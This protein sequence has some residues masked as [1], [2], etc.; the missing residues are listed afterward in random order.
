M[1]LHGIPLRGFAISTVIF[2]ISQPSVQRAILR[3]TRYV[4]H[5][6]G[7]TIHNRLC[8]EEHREN[9]PGT[10]I[11]SAVQICENIANVFLCAIAA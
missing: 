11:I 7:S 9:P 6:R 5:F 3:I 10:Y 8:G 1:F 2:A 4:S